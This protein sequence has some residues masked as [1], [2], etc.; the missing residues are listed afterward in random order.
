[1]RWIALLGSCAAVVIVMVANVASAACVGANGQSR[2]GVVESHEIGPG[3]TDYDRFVRLTKGPVSIQV[4]VQNSYDS[5]GDCSAVNDRLTMS[6]HWTQRGDT[7]YGCLDPSRRGP[8]SFL[9][10]YYVAQK[11]GPGNRPGK[12]FV[13]IKNPG[14]CTVEYN[15]VCRDGRHTFK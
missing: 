2:S 10:C 6:L 15:L 12:W 9:S 4:D 1:M 13:R 3:K 11:L 8:H 5:R 7:S 14:R